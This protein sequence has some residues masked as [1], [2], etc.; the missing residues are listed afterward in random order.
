MTHPNTSAFKVQSGSYSA[1]S[2]PRRRKGLSVLSEPENTNND[3]K[4]DMYM[5]NGKPFI[6]LEPSTGKTSS[7]FFKDIFGSKFSN[8]L[9]TI[10]FSNSFLSFSNESLLNSS[11]SKDNE[12]DNCHTSTTSSDAKNLNE[13]NKHICTNESES[14]AIKHAIHSD[15][16]KE[17]GPEKIGNAQYKNNFETQNTSATSKVTTSSDDI[18][19]NENI[20]NTSEPSA[21]GGRQHFKRNE[22]PRRRPIR[23]L[24]SSSIKS[25]SPCR[26]KNLPI[27]RIHSFDSG[28]PSS[29]RIKKP[30]IQIHEDNHANKKINHEQSS[31]GSNEH[32]R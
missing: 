19:T 13:S 9:S 32:Y 6:N 2:T 25:Y 11:G 5:K 24:T 20:G 1:H 27:K 4:D 8:Y 23:S 31:Y 29:N 18:K 22:I 16:A 26:D 17:D 30:V 7:P 10:S 14:L 12:K 3:T 28:K 15:A 21:D